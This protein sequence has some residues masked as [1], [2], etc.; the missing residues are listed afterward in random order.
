MQ[1]SSTLESVVVYARGAICARRISLDGKNGPAPEQLRVEGLPLTLEPSLVRAQ[2]RSG[3]SGLAVRD[4]RLDFAVQR[5]VP[6][7]VP[8]AHARREAANAK[9]AALRAEQSRLQEE[10]DALGQLRP[11]PLPHPRG[12]PPRPA[13]LTG[14]LALALA[15]DEESAALAER[16]FALER[17]LEE[18]LAQAVHWERVAALEKQGAEITRVVRA[19]DLFLTPAQAGPAELML[20][21]GVRGALWSPSYALTLAP[22]FAS[23]TLSVRAQVAQK[24]GEDW[25]G[26][27]LAVSTA[28]L[29]RVAEVPKLRSL[30][31]GRA[32]PAP[33]TGWRPPPSGLDELLQD[34]RA[35]AG[36]PV[37]PPPKVVAGPP[38]PEPLLQAA[39]GAGYLAGESDYG[40]LAD[41]DEKNRV[42]RADAAPVRPSAPPPPSG[43]AP[44]PAALLSA[45]APG[46][47][48]ELSR[49]RAGAPVAKKAM[50]A[51]AAEMELAPE[52]LG[53]GGEFGQANRHDRAEPGPLAPPAGWLDYPRLE[54][55]GPSAALPGRLVPAPEP[56]LATEPVRQALR[57]S[58]SVAREVEARE[59]PRHAAP[60]R[61]SAGHFDDRYDAPAPVAIEGDGRWHSVALFDAEV[62]MTPGLLC[63]PAMD[64]KVYRSLALRNQ[65]AHALLAGPAEVT[66]GGTFLAT[67]AFPTLA[68]GGEERIGLGVEEAVQVSR[69][70]RYR[71]E[72][73]GLLG[74]SSLLVHEVELEAAN[75]LGAKVEL[76]VRERVPVSHEKDVQVEELSVK[77]AWGE[78]LGEAKPVEGGREWRIALGPNERKKL[79]A[80]FQIRIPAGRM[81]AGGNRRQ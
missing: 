54:L 33:S 16:L 35:A 65:S 46:A 60:V 30:R 11:R 37:P 26:V 69:N 19:V 7:Q 49:S 22:G 9:V 58:A 61:Q 68:P 75:R 67:V 38:M 8:E 10:L 51:P 70:V 45:P 40:G 2:V 53:E 47:R 62:T 25:S 43:G 15:V 56:A 4:V 17:E 41:D 73:G 50:R 79:E 57:A 63:V 42:A 66:L 27:K 36:P 23:G 18:A 5:E 6:E 31:I 48:R 12:Q 1:V 76:T 80:K 29:M 39:V 13:A 72:Q 81:L 24:T 34:F 14:T 32:Q 28:D 64:P 52:E 20:E 55:A 21:Y 78:L 77:P 71:E 74:G 3:P 44:G 59:L